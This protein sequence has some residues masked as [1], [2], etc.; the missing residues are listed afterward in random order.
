MTDLSAPSEPQLQSQIRNASFLATLLLEISV[1]LLIQGIVPV[2]VSHSAKRTSQAPSRPSSSHLS[3]IDTSTAFLGHSSFLIDNYGNQQSRCLALDVA[4]CS[5]RSTLKRAGVLTKLT[6]AHFLPGSLRVSAG[7][8]CVLR[9]LECL[10]RALKPSYQP[11]FTHSPD[12]RVWGSPRGG[13]VAT[14]AVFHT[15]HNVF[16]FWNL[17]VIVS[18]SVG[19]RNT[20]Q[21]YTGD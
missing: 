16:S 12:L 2:P 4:R 1:V 10:S 3:S 8:M 14:F 20:T 21:W 5:I 18:E 6:F 13:N 7:A 11:R 19:A 15:V 17:Q 9:W